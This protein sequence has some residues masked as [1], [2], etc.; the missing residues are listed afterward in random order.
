MAIKR[1]YKVRIFFNS[2]SELIVFGIKLNHSTRWNYI[3]SLISIALSNSNWPPE[4][5]TVHWG[6]LDGLQ[7]FDTSFSYYQRTKLNIQIS[8][9]FH[10]QI[11]Y[12]DNETFR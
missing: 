11:R 7:Y 10:T 6:R 9:Q 2:Y 8:Q 12:I 3:K 5:P 1:E 4:S